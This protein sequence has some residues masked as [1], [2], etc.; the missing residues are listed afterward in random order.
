[1]LPSLPSG[2]MFRQDGAPPYCGVTVRK[3][4]NEKLPGSWI[5]RE[6]PL[7]WSAYSPALT[8][9]DFILWW[10]VKEKIYHM[11]CY[12][13]TQLKKEAPLLLEALMGIWYETY[14]RITETG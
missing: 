7:P 14:G 1:M 10:S 11:P 2:T 13:L 12:N 3:I 9:P 8:H 6:G 4:L 5:R